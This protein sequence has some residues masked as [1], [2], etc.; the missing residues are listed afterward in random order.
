MDDIELRRL[1]DEMRRVHGEPD[2]V[3]V[4]S[5]AGGYPRSVVDSIVSFANTAGGIIIIGV[6]ETADFAAVGVSDPA[7]YRD[8]VVGQARDAVE[9]PAL[10]DV[11][12][13]ELD[14]AQLVV[15]EVPEA[16]P[17]HKP[18]HLRS[19]GPTTGALVRSGDGD[20]RMTAAEIGLLY[21]S[22][23]QP[24]FDRRPVP[25]ATIEDLDRGVLTR[26]LERVRSTAASLR[27]EDEQTVLLRIGAVVLHEGH[28]RPTLGG[29][30]AFGSYPQ[31]FFPQLFVSFVSVPADP[32]ED[33]ERF[34]DNVSIRGSIPAM[35]GG[36]L[37]AVRRNLAARS[38][39]TGEGRTESLDFSLE[40]VRE[41]VVN[42]LM[43]RDYSGVTQ[44]AQVQVELHPSEL[45]IRSPGGLFGA[46]SVEDLG[47]PGVSSSRNATLVSLLSDTYVP[48]TD[49]LVA[50]NRA[51]GVP[52]MVRESRRLGL[53]RPAFDS[54]ISSFTVT[55]SSSA[56]LSDTVR[57]WISTLPLP[58]GT[59]EREIALAML[60]RGPVTNEML[61]E[62]G[63]D[64]IQAGSVLRELVEAQIAI[65]LGGRRYASYVL[66]DRFRPGREKPR[67]APDNGVADPGGSTSNRHAVREA[68]RANGPLGAR[69]IADRTGLHR[70][71]VL[72]IL[73]EGI[74]SG[75]IVADGAPRS[76]KRVYSIRDK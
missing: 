64:R 29:L 63:L 3:E 59:R 56:L 26:S 19:K 37:A 7:A 9:P 50:E 2:R 53:P 62:W 17:V 45:L 32:G 5:G 27:S 12:M 76:P 14:G 48:G 41:A 54:R 8:A 6:D 35:V 66:D 28:I 25:A 44:G 16:D 57:G 51:S 13:L 38:I 42:A 58:A 24:D 20:R 15:V 23:T 49:R 11:E 33:G 68:L 69:V 75:D 1:L 36:T 34:L 55:M 47:E 18:L 71:T 39:V 70:R 72:G 67:E 60:L 21:A 10:V 40:A 61:R 46:V 73:T 22:R 31:Q 74:I 52:I 30:L 43:H 65:K 4:K